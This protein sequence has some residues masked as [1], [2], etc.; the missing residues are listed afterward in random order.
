M[1]WEASTLL[2]F[3]ADWSMALVGRTGELIL[4]PGR[5]DGSGDAL[6]SDCLGGRRGD[7]E[8]V[9]LSLVSVPVGSNLRSALL[10][11]EEGRVA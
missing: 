5:G 11:G 7:R 9:D 1:F 4:F 8:L 3:G 6:L 10:S 2:A